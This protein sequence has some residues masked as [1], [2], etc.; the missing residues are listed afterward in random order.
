[1]NRPHLPGR[2]HDSGAARARQS[3]HWAECSILADR[4]PEEIA[5]EMARATEHG[6]PDPG[7]G[8]PGGAGERLR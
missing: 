4:G 1:M 3:A 2:H 6:D 8:G 5:T 7:D